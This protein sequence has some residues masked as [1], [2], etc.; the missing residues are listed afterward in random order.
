[1]ARREAGE[2]CVG[3]LEG[4]ES[5]RFALPAFNRLGDIRNSPEKIVEV[6]QFPPVNL[7]MTASSPDGRATGHVS[8]PRLQVLL[9]LAHHN[10]E[11]NLWRVIRR[12]SVAAPAGWISSMQLEELD[13][14]P[15]LNLV[16]GN[17]PRVKYDTA[18]TKMQRLGCL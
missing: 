1:M 18:I 6:E 8:K 16:I 13:S 9:P 14:G 7:A 3:S 11:N 17:D 5:M 10:V 12:I 4:S 15:E 2:H